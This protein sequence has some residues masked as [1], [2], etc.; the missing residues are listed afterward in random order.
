MAVPTYQGATGG[1][2]SSSSIAG[3]AWVSGHQVDDLGMCI[4]G[5]SDRVNGA[6]GTHTTPTN[7]TLAPTNPSGFSTLTTGSCVQVEVASRI[8]TST[9]EA[10]ASFSGDLGSQFCKHLLFRGVDTTTPIETDAVGVNGTSATSHTITT[11]LTSSTNDG[12]VVLII[13][14]DTDIGTPD[15]TLISA[16]S[17][18]NLTNVTKQNSNQWNTNSGLGLHIFTGELVTAGAVGNWSITTTSGGTHAWWCGVLKSANPSGGGGGTVL[19]GRKTL[20]G[21]GG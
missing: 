10:N 18:S 6:A 19:G 9:T 21:V 13:A 17:N 2:I 3:I 5:T 14:F 7:F 4:I 15:T 11:G 1:S 16:E 8:A 12:L 20:L